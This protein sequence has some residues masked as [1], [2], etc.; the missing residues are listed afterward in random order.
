MHPSHGSNNQRSQ[1]EPVGGNNKGWGLGETYKDG[2][3]GDG[4]YP[5]YQNEI[6]PLHARYYYTIKGCSK[7]NQNVL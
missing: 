1:A 6:L 5:Y 3:E 4:Y 2:G 7:S